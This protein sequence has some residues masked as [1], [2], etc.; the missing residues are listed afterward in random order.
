[1]TRRLAL[2]IGNS[3]YQDA[4]LAR[5]V[6]P[7]ADAGDL[8]AVLRAAEIGG[9]DEVVALVNSS[10]PAVRRAIARLFADKKPD[11]LLLLYFSGHGVR[12]DRGLLYLAV[13]DTEHD[14][15]NATAIPAAFITEEMDRSRS[16]RQVLIL[17]C[18]HSG[19]FAHGA[20]GTPGLSVGTGAA[21]E[22]TG[23]GRVILTAT[24]STQYAWEGDQLIGSAENSVFTQCLL[25]GLHSGRADLDGDGNITLDELYD[26]V[27]EQ[28][29]SRTP[30]QTPRKFAYNQQGD[31]VVARNPKP[32]ITPAELPPELRQALESPFS[33]VREGALR[34]LERLVQGSRRGLV[35]AALE[36]LK[37]LTQDDSRRLSAAAEAILADY[38]HSQ[39]LPAEQQRQALEAAEP[40]RPARLETERLAAQRAEEAR[41]AAERAAA[42]QAARERAERD[43]LAQE[44]VAAEQAAQVKA[45]AEQKAIAERAA[46]DRRA[47]ERRAQQEQ[48]ARQQHEAQLAAQARLEAEQTAAAGRAAREQAAH[49]VLAMPGPAGQAGRP[50]A[51]AQ[52]DDHGRPAAP[53]LALAVVLP[54]ALVAIG[55]GLG[56]KLAHDV[57][58]I[59]AGEDKSAVLKIVADAVNWTL[60]DVVGGAALGLLLRFFSRTR[61][62]LAVLG[63]IIIWGSMAAAAWGFRQVANPLIGEEASVWIAL[64]GLG[65]VDGLL[66]VALLRAGGNRMT[67]LQWLALP[68]GWSVALAAAILVN[69]ASGW[70]ADPWLLGLIGGAI[71]S[72]VTFWAL[73]QPSTARPAS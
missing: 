5:L 38:A 44:R 39:R 28:V 21:F 6:T 30:K 72:A 14:L 70:S 33:S 10:A 18:C 13:Q 2:V 69:S 56:W 73:A 59:I 8:A 60:G 63:L 46:Q 11:D 62:W 1:M 66:L 23:Y 55:Y 57:A 48:L 19:A 29:V 26:F 27:Y 15:L 7:A 20:K 31:V 4:Q 17:D 43:R 61:S 32:A 9:F 45:E 47:A 16:R 24:D 71:G 54:T 50:A 41:R 58:I 25:E 42:E 34:E 53:N 40:D 35:L 12:D 3:E 68:V 64:T 67:G 51:S 49:P 36:A 52:P 22:G 37:R 65:L